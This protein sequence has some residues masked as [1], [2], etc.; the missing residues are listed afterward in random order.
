MVNCY[1]DRSS[2]ETL[3]SIQQNDPTLTSLSIGEGGFYSGDA[4]DFSLLGSAISRNTRL[5]SLGVD[6]R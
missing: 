2:E 4:G 6:N 3:L 5:T 1:A